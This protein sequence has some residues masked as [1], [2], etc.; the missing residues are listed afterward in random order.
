MSSEPK[1]REKPAAS[2][3]TI[4]R[5]EF[6]GEAG[7]FL[8]RLRCELEWDTEAF[9][10][11]TAAMQACA[12]AHEGVDTI[13]RWIAHG[14]WFVEHFARDWSSHP[15]FP[16]VHGDPYYTEACERL[17]D[18]SYWLFVGESSYLPPE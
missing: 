7:S 6:D 3:E 8:I 9:S 10:R 2:W 14:F 13:A 17:H 16:R 11:L 5:R 12:Q 1:A 15:D 18:L 4:L